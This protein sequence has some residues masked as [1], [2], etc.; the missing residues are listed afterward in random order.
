[1]CLISASL[2]N[3]ELC[4]ALHNILDAGML[5]EIYGYNS[6]WDKSQVEIGLACP[7][8]YSTMELS[9]VKEP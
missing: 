5:S 6:L 1:M 4:I 8:L 9:A 3:C 7:D 2:L